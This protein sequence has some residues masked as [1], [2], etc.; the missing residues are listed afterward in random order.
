[1]DNWDAALPTMMDVIALASAVSLMLSV[2][3][4]VLAANGYDLPWWTVDA[5]GGQSI[6]IPSVSMT[7][8]SSAAV[9]PPLAA[10]SGVGPQKQGRRDNG[11]ICHLWYADRPRAGGQFV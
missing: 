9:A 10:Y 2:T 11:S 3:S 7:L 5:G 6:G 8:G 1:M 4:V